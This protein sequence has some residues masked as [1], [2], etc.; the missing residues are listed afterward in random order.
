MRLI[1]VNFNEV[2]VKKL[3]FDAAKEWNEWKNKNIQNI[4]CILIE[5]G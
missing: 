4:Y 3:D 5:N 1:E 2:K